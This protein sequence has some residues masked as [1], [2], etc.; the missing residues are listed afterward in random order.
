MVREQVTRALE[1]HP[2]TFDAFK[3]RLNQLT[4]SEIIKIWELERQS[5]EEWASQAKPIL[6]VLGINNYLTI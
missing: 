3:N 4:Y 2:S 6:Y 1:I 5:K